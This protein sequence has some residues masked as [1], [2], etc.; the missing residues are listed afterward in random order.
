MTRPMRRALLV[1]LLTTA[2]GGGF[3]WECSTRLCTTRTRRLGQRAE[4]W[5]WRSPRVRARA[6]CR[7]VGRRGPAGEPELL[8]AVRWP[9]RVAA[10]F[11]AGH[12]KIEAPVTPRKLVE[13]MI[14]GAAD[15]LVAV[16]VPEGK[17]LI[18]VIDILDAAGSRP[19]PS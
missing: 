4:P 19:R 3:W 7:V 15:E 11:K 8:P 18:E 12:Y 5:K 9:A 2:L 17:N 13:L 6:K 14:R 1:F 10:R 16:T